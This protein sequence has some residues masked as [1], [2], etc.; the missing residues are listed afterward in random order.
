VSSTTLRPPSSGPRQDE[1]GE[2]GRAEL[3]SLASWEAPVSPP[4]SEEVPLPVLVQEARAASTEAERVGVAARINRQ[5]DTL[6]AGD[7]GR[8]V[9]DLLHQLLEGDQLAGLEDAEGRTCRAAATEALLRL[10]YPFALEVRPE[11]LEHLRSLDKGA[12]GLPWTSWAAL[13]TLG[14]GLLAQWLALPEPGLSTE[15]QPVLPLIVLMGLSLLTLVPA[16]LGP[17]RS[18]SR[19]AGLLGLLVL[20]LVQLYLGVSGGYYGT[21]SGAAG[22]LAWLLLLLPRR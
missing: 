6:E 3:P 7:A 12:G 9:A 14:A 10:G 19:R 16:M 20:A 17:E 2:E 11:D 22:L 5:L 21:L 13:G 1:P 4:P 15:G 8:Q 18:D